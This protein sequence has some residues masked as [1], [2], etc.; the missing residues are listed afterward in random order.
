MD[1]H[2]I[3]A[4]DVAAAKAGF[5]SS[6]G[7][8][9]DNDPRLPSEKKKPRGRRRADPLADAW[10][11]EVAPMLKAAPGL[12]PVTIFE[13]LQRRRP[14]LGGGIRRT[15][16]RRIRTWKAQ[17]GP[18]QEVMFRQA[19]EPGRQGLSDFTDV[20]GLG[21]IVDGAPLAHR[22]YHFRL[23]FSV[24]RRAKLTPWWSGPL[25]PDNSHA[26]DLT[27]GRGLRSSNCCGLR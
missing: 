12:R 13:E 6:T 27:M 16:E 3:N 15:L 20:S 4:T 18:D 2:R 8:R 21:I 19:H 22:L 26:A 7:R 11:A 9:L 14:D 17:H 10:D 5:S 1:F 24:I 23:A 25:G